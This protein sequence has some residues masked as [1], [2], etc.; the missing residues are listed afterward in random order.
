[1]GPRKLNVSTHCIFSVTIQRWV[2][3]PQVAPST[4]GNPNIQLNLFKTTQLGLQREFKLC[5]GICVHFSF[6]PKVALF[7]LKKVR[8]RK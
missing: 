5:V 4:M 3:E 2:K 7:L 1:M 8:K 6:I